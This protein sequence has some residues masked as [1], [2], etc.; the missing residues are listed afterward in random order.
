MNERATDC[1]ARR[2]SSSRWHA[3]DVLQRLEIRVNQLRPSGRFPVHF[4]PHD[5]EPP[6]PRTTDFMSHMRHKICRVAFS[7]SR[8]HFAVK[9][10][11]EAIA[12]AAQVHLDPS[13]ACGGVGGWSG[14]WWDSGAPCACVRFCEAGAS[15]SPERRPPAR[16]HFHDGSSHPPFTALISCVPARS[17]SDETG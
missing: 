5:L 8:Q 13:R 6:I 2:N 9:P 16:R 14:A 3:H 4:T 1:S 17:L 11:R 7:H 15:R 12:L 10:P